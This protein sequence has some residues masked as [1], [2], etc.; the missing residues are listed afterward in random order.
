MKRI[1]IALV[2]KYTSVVNEKYHLNHRY[3]D[4]KMYNQLI[5]FEQLFSNIKR[6]VQHLKNISDNL[7][8]TFK[9]VSLY[10]K[11][12]IN[13]IKFILIL[14]NCY[15]VLDALN[16]NSIKNLIKYSNFD[17][18]SYI[19]P[20]DASEEEKEKI[21]ESY[22]SYYKIIKLSNYDEINIIHSFNEN[23]GYNSVCLLLLSDGR[24]AM[25]SKVNDIKVYNLLSLQADFIIKDA[26]TK[27]I[28][29]LI[30]L[31]NE[32]VL[33]SSHDKSIKVWNIN[34]N[35]YELEHTI[36]EPNNNIN[37]FLLLNIYQRIDLYIVIELTV[38]QFMRVILLI[39][40]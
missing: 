30:Q 39:K 26:H 17:L 27:S 18:E 10:I 22:L 38:S 20:I 35:D 5:D 36:L 32:R 14:I 28:N 29:N 19:I 6:A 33:S 24:I 15:Y 9:Q 23:Q 34:Q 2:K 11:N 3:V 37:Y 4:L 21:I 8:K 16:Y 1:I 7:G 31:Q 25:T 12:N 13:I 40:K